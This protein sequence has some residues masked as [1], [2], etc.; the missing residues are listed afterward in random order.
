MKRFFTALLFVSSLC[1][2]YICCSDTPVA[3]QGGSGTETV[4][5][6][7]VDTLGRPVNN[8]FVQVSS[9]DTVNPQT[10]WDV[11]N[12]DGKYLIEDIKAGLYN[13][14]G[15]TSDT[16]LIIFMDI[17]YAD[18]S[19]PLDL[20]IDTMRAP[21]SIS[22]TVLLDSTANPGVLVY[23]PGTSYSAYSD[24]SGKFVI[25]YFFNNISLKQQ[26]EYTNYLEP[27][28]KF[29]FIQR[30]TI[31]RNVVIDGNTIDL[32][33]LDGLYLDRNW[34]LENNAQIFQVMKGMF[35]A[36]DCFSV[37]QIPDTS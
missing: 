30:I 29:G 15:H 16:S 7:L 35:K 11:T 17:L 19:K 27:D 12:K 1:V 18:D 26:S 13:L 23:I 36:I 14:E 37:Y 9:I 32:K 4:G 34:V 24:D 3:S 31:P 6:I 10:F 22:G 21:G 20:G 28:S 2:L 5:G 33:D 8:A 25:K